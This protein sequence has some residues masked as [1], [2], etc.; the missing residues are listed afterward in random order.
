MRNW[1]NSSLV[2]HPFEYRDTELEKDSFMQAADSVHSSI[3]G[4]KVRHEQADRTRNE[5]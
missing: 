3:L 5:V 4:A 1:Y 2:R